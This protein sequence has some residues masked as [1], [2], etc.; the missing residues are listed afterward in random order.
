MLKHEIDCILFCDNDMCRDND[1]R[2]KKF[3]CV[4][5]NSHISNISES[6]YLK[7]FVDRKSEKIHFVFSKIYKVFK[8]TDDMLIY[9]LENGHKEHFIAFFDENNKIYISDTFDKVVE[10]LA[11]YII[12]EKEGKRFLIEISFKSNKLK[13][14][15]GPNFFSASTQNYAIMYDG[16]KCLNFLDKNTLTIVGPRSFSGISMLKGQGWM[17]VTNPIEQY[18]IVRT[19]DFKYSYPYYMVRGYCYTK[20][21]K[22]VQSDRYVLVDTYYKGKYIFDTTKMTVVGNEG[23]HEIQ[24]INEETVRV[25]KDDKWSI[26]NL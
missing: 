11:H 20:N 16:A 24:P 17:I 26:L 4:E 1:K 23:Y 13:L 18:I 14:I 15:T 5:L 2:R 8:A 19:T 25:R 3:A 10:K 6:L 12:C 22:T 21:G 9:E 7:A